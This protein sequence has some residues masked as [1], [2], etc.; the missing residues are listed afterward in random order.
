MAVIRS[1]DDPNADVGAIRA[2]L[3]DAKTAWDRA[4]TYVDR[5]FKG[6]APSGLPVEQ[7]DRFQ[8]IINLKTANAIGFDP[9][10]L[11]SRAD[12][13][14]QYSS[15]DRQLPRV[16][17]AETGTGPT[18]LGDAQSGQLSGG[19]RDLNPTWRRGRQS[20]THC[21]GPSSRQCT[22]HKE[23]SLRMK[24]RLPRRSRQQRLALSQFLSLVVRH[25]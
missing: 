8:F 5:I 16:L 18:E 7:L 23:K 21:G 9:T 1:A 2:E 12:E 4:V 24:L 11:L 20:L 15:S 13:V 25:E 22:Q 17:T 14:I 19:P 3:Y 6:A 10:S